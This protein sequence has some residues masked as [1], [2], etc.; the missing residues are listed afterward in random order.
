MNSLYIGLGGA[1]IAAVATYAKMAQGKG[2]IRNDEF[3]YLDTDEYMVRQFPVMGND[4]FLLGGGQISLPMLVQREQQYLSD[5]HASESNKKHAQHFFSW[6]DENVPDNRS[7]RPLNVGSGANRMAARAMLFCDYAPVKI[8]IANKLPYVDENG[9]HQIRRVFVVS[10][11]CGGTGSGIVLD[12]LYMIQEICTEMVANHPFV[13]LLLIMPEEYIRE[14]PGPQDVRYSKYC[15][16]AYALFDELNACLKDYYSGEGDKA[17]MQM[18]KYTCCYNDVLPFQFEVFHNAILFDSVGAYGGPM[19]HEQCAN[20]VADFLFAHEIEPMLGA[21][22]NVML[23][24]MKSQSANERFIKGFATTGVYMAQTWEELTRKYVKEKFIYQML[25][26]GFIGSQEEL[27]SSVLVKD[28]CVFADEINC[29]ISNYQSQIHGYITDNLERVGKKELYHIV[30]AIKQ[31]VNQRDIR[32]FEDVFYGDGVRMDL[33]LN[34]LLMQVKDLTC[35]LCIEWAKRYNLNHTIHLIERLD[36]MCDMRWKEVGL[37]IQDAELKLSPFVSIGKNRNKVLALFADLV[38]YVVYRNLSDNGFLDDCRERLREAIG[39]IDLNSFEM[40][41]GVS[42]GTWEH[43]YIKH[44]MTIYY[45]STKSVWP[46]LDML[47]DRKHACLCEDNQVERDYASL[48]LQDGKGPDMSCDLD[49]DRL[50]YS[51]KNRCVE[52]L[53]GDDEK[54]STCFVDLMKGSDRT[55]IRIAF[56]AYAQKV[57]QKAEELANAPE[58]SKPFATV[59]NRLSSDEQR[60]LIDKLNSFDSTFLSTYYRDVQRPKISLYLA[61][62]NSMNGLQGALAMGRQPAMNNHFVQST[63]QID[64]VAKLN[65]ELGYTPLDYRYYDRYKAEFDRCLQIPERIRNYQPFIDKR[66]L[67]DRQEGE[68][69]ADMFL[70]DAEQG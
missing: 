48:V 12:I 4:F 41:Y 7:G 34:R 45:D 10:G 1:G 14:L 54:W 58:L 62:F 13:N 24:P 6:F 38:R 39:Y 66:F 2:I 35:S 19:S 64:C 49:N 15:L 42:V 22:I 20:N 59:F 37:R 70:R 69:L 67:T 32:V 63:N 60:A 26:H 5:P 55:G 25:Y 46:N 52:E 9:N 8:T 33:E 44:L 57:K 17:G 50:L 21:W 18:N 61:D 11:T 30:E 43:H 56:E 28:I 53:D 47:L 31:Q 40:T 23:E 51:Y 16:N 27:E 3:L 68:S 65:V 36:C 29:L